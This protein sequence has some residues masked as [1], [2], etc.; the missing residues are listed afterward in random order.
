[1]IY[2]FAD[3]EFTDFKN[4]D[5]ISVALVSEDGQHE[6]Y[7]EISDHIADYRSDFVNQVV[8]PL[9]EGGAKSKTYDWAVL[10][11]RDWLNALPYDD[12]EIVV[13]YVGDWHL[14]NEMLK[15]Q[16]SNKRIYS[17][18]LTAA[19]MHMLHSR[20]IHTSENISKAYAALVNETPKYFL[21][22]P[23]QHNALVDARANRHGWVAA[24]EAA[25]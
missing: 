24:Y 12:I 10:D 5:L 8:V 22:D 7:V 9:L 20:G 25:K 21:Q 2:L 3:C 16:P 17:K 4:M 15:A 6:F 1:M 14:I 18:M 13:D 11:L 23:R 19:L